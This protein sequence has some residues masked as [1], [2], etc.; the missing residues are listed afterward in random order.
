MIP[1]FMPPLGARLA[2]PASGNPEL[3]VNGTFDT[4]TDWTKG[5]GWTIS[6]G[7]ANRTETGTQ[8]LV[9]TI[10]TTILTSTEYILTYDLISS[11][12]QILI[13]IGNGGLS[14]Y[15][16]GSAQSGDGTK[17]ITATTSATAGDNKIYVFSNVGN[18]V[19]SIDNLSLK[20]T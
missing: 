10:S 19:G 20:R 3:I 8:T 5:T 9:Q 17:T 15:N 11:T 1:G 2:A 12:G 18:F 7:T 6:G 4:D 16:F 13:R 14:A